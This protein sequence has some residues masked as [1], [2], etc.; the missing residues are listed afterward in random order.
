VQGACRRHELC[1]LTVNDI[2][3]KGDMLLV[4]IPKTKNDKPRSFVVTDNFYHIY[5]KYAILRP[6]NVSTT[7]FFLN[8]RDGRCSQQVIGINSF[9]SMPKTVALFLKLKDPE[10][11]TG[12]TFRRTSATLL[13][14]SG[15]DL[16]TLKR[17]GGWKSNTVAEGY[18]EDSVCQKKRIGQQIANAISEKPSTSRERPHHQIN[19]ND[20]IT[21]QSPINI[22][23]QEKENIEIENSNT[24]NNSQSINFHFSNCPN[25]SII[26]NKK[27]D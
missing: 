23:I 22:H 4:K 8:Y 27:N 21:T 9:G 15:A 7:R 24:C 5:K 13:A 16:L 17:H 26:I 11:Y 3:D 25:I 2:E 14:D 19:P 20:Q 10:S 1:D 18:V 12:H 6:N